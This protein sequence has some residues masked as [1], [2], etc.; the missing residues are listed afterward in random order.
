MFLRA[1]KKN[2]KATGDSY[3]S[4]FYRAYR[5]LLSG[6]IRF[7][8]VS[9]MV[10]LGL[11]AGS[12]YGFQYV[13]RSFFPASTRPQFLVDYW[14]P[15]GTHI[16]D[17][18][19]DVKAIERWIGDLEPV[20]HVASVI[21]QGGMR[22]L[23]TY[24]PEKSNTGYAQFIVEVDDY[25]KIS[26]LETQIEDYIRAH[27]PDAE[28][29][30]K[31]INLGPGT[32]GK[33]QP[34][35]TGPDPH[36][37]R[38]VEKE[39]IAILED[40]GARGIRSDWRNRV[41]VVKPV[42]SE[43]QANIN[44][45]SRPMVA[46][47]LKQ[48]YEGRQV[49][50]Y[51]E[52]DRLLPIVLRAPDEERIQTEL[53]PYLQIWSPAANR[54]IPISQVVSKFETT[55][56]DEIVMRRN[57]KRTITVHADARGE[58]PAE[59]LA[60]VMPR[61]EAISLPAGYHISWGGEYEDTARSQDG[62]NASLPYF[63]LGMV[64]IVIFLFNS[65]RDPLIIWLTVPLALIGVT[66]GLLG[67]D[68]PFGFMALLGFLSLSGMLIKNAI[69][70]IDQIRLERASGKSDL[71]AV[72]DSGVSRLMPVAMAALT[73]AFGMIPLLTD[74]FFIAMAVTIIFGL[75]FAT[76]LTMVFV[77][78]LYTIFYRIRGS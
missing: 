25:T 20:T 65:L 49:G 36:E 67:F 52:A 59:L 60:R 9:V 55:F 39:M 38:Q 3:D 44:G 77:P 32:G 14:L 69:V 21:G 71:Q 27:Y 30:T 16:D 53:L 29:N 31:Q 51:R 47:T 76:V 62:L 28:P 42:I 73:T 58:V 22:F 12:M 6:A 8:W 50:V 41:K 15:Q 43:E 46:N 34:R 45:I 23:V 54:R 33:L 11:F 78:V 56:E 13:G 1:S 57:R 4:V 18:T 72:I 24:S 19:R 37:L 40:E 5:K 17:T 48:A 7:R 10:V 68:Q 74:A 63:F 26:A 70:L 75:M 2:D 61:V 35:V 66:W 64:L